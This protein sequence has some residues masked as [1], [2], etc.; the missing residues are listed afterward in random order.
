MKLRNVIKGGAV[1]AAVAVAAFAIPTIPTW[2]SETPGSS[3]PVVDAAGEVWGG[4][5]QGEFGLKVCGPPGRVVRV[6][7]VLSDGTNDGRIVPPK[8]GC[9]VSP[10]GASIVRF[11][12]WV[13]NFANPWHLS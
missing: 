5:S 7:Y 8:G 11:R 2:A 13:D 6:E 9:S 10:P 3:V 1:T 4:I 12:G